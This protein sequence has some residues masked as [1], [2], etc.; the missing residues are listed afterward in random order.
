MMVRGESDREAPPGWHYDDDTGALMRDVIHRMGRRCRNWDYCGKGVYLITITLADR[1]SR[2]LGRLC[3]DNARGAFVAMS[4]LGA[5]IEALMWRMPEF[6][7][8]IEVLGVMVMPDH[9][10]W[11]L[12]VARRLPPKKPLGIALRGFKGGATR[13]YWDGLGFSAE[14]QRAGGFSAE[15]RAVAPGLKSPGPLFAEG[16][17]DTILFD[18]KAVA[19]ALG[20]LADNP[21]RLWEKQAHP[22]LFT[23]LRD[24]PVDLGCGFTAH[25]AAIGNHH[26]LKAH[27]ILQVQCSRRFFA[28]AR[29]AAGKL[30]KDAPPRLET[31]EFRESTEALLEEAA[32]GAVLVSPCI[33]EGE[34]EIARRAFAA[35]RR[36]ITLANKGFPPLYKPGGKLFDACAAGSLLMLA[37]INW[38]YLPGEKKMTREDACALNR[39]SQLIAGPGAVEIMYTGV[40]P[41]N[42]DLIAHDEVDAA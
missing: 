8:E 1:R 32:H 15:V 33:S 38:P 36:V 3:H 35:G 29:D 6:S 25:F 37:P 7:P 9:I 27:S 16:Y 14:A 30:L 10:H 40:R 24:L 31:D 21:R 34:R 18:D 17:V 4:K 23:V 28:Y 39:I 42:V 12:R 41:E 19:S 5:Q 20:Y 2:A 26:L 22:E 13:L 11:V